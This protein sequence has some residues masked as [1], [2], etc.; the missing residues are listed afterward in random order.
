[1]KPRA[2]DRPRKLL[3]FPE[4]RETRGIRYTRQHLL[5]LE[6]LGKFPLRVYLSAR[7]VGWVETEIDQYIL[8][9]IYAR[10]SKRP[11]TM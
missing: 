2:L 4:L 8:D 1:M 5:R 10:K 7:A 6:K 11:A 9:K 3:L